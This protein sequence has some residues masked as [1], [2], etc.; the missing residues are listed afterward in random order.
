MENVLTIV[1]KTVE[2]CNI[3][4][5]YCYFFNGIDKSFKQHPPYISFETIKKIT[6]FLKEGSKD[7][8]IQR[9]RLGIHG[10]EPL[11]QKKTSFDEMCNYLRDELEP[12]VK[13][14]LTLQTNGMLLDEEWIN[15]IIK[16]NIGLGISID[17]PKE[18]HDKY[19][20]DHFGKG[21]YVD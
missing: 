18:Y 20:V 11:M 5:T 19:R 7:L 14:T 6:K 8:N 9:V 1:L 16:H 17:G 21:T 4:C 2:R 13:V 15:L 3:N 10:G 12:D